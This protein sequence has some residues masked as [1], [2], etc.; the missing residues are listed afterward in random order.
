M[1]KKINFL[2]S[3]D[4]VEKIEVGTLVYKLIMEEML[5]KHIS[6]LLKKDTD[7]ILMEDYIL[8]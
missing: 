2:I 1:S 5:C 7:D 3:D 8:W 4:D 6:E